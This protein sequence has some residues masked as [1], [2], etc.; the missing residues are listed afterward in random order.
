VVVPKVLGKKEFGVRGQRQ[1]TS[2]E[3]REYDGLWVNRTMATADTVHGNRIVPSI[4][5][6]T[7]VILHEPQ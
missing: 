5:Q 4:A 6:L 1:L 3:F 2:L 7:G